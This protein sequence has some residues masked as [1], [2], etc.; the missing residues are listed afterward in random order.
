MVELDAGPAL[1]IMALMAFNAAVALMHIIQT[2]TEITVLGCVLI[3]LID[4]A[5]LAAH[6]GMG[7]A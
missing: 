7:T 2:V 4:V 3:A 5:I 1:V 6:I